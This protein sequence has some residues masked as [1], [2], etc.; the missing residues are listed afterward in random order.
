MMIETERLLLREYT[1][2]DFDDLYEIQEKQG[3]EP[4]DRSEGG[5][6]KLSGHQIKQFVCMVFCFFFAAAAA[7]AAESMPAS[8]ADLQPESVS[9]G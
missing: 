2:D 3:A 8:A 6:L 1:M 5:Y 9:G 4:K 7:A